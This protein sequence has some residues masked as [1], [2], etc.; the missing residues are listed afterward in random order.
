MIRI[1]TNL[2]DEDFPEGFEVELHKMLAPVMGKP[3]DVTNKS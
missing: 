1:E 2:K 3:I